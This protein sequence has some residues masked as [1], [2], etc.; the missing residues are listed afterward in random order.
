MM[1]IL[2]SQAPARQTA[3]DTIATLSSRLQSATLLEDRRAAIQGLRSFAKLYPASVA[4]G[5]LRDLVACL[6][7][8]ADDLDTIK[9]VL[10]TILNL[11]EPDANSD[12]ASEE[13]TVWLADEFALKQDNITA[14]LDLLENHDLYPR[15]YSLQIL[16]H[17]AAA[18]PDRTQ[19]AVFAA[20][21]G[22]SRVVAI[23]DDKREMVRN[24]ALMLLIALTPTSAELQKVIAFED[25]FGRVFSIIEAEGGLTHGA[26][27]VQDCLSLLGNLLKLNTSN[28]SYFREIGGVSRIAKLLGTALAEQNTPEGVSEWIKPQRDV[29]VWGLLTLVQLFLPKGAPGTSVNQQLFWQNAVLNHILQLAFHESMSVGIRAKALETCGDIIRSNASLQERFGDLPVRLPSRDVPQING[30]GTPAPGARSQNKTPEPPKPV[31]EDV[32]VI[33]ALLELSLEPAPLSMFD[34]RIASCNCVKA[35]IEGHNGIRIHVLRRAIEGHK[36]G[37]DTI[38]NILTVLLEPSSTRTTSDPYQQWMASVILMHLLVDNPETKELALSV[39][40]GDAENGEEVVTFV[41]S[42]TSNIIAGVQHVEDERALLGCLM[43]LCIWLF[44]TPEAVN[45]LLGEG[46]NVQGLIAA[47]KVSNTSMPL[48]SSLSALLIGIVYEFSTKDSPVPRSSLHTLLT[49]NL[50]RETY[51]DRMTRLREDPL[52]RDFE[53]LP[54]TGNGG[55]PDVFFDKTFVDFLKDNFSRLLRAIDREPG[56]E[57]SI[58]ANGVQKGVSRD[59]VDSLRAE[60]EEQRRVLEATNNDMLQLQRKLEDEELEHRRTRESTTVEL[61]RIKQINQSLQAGHEQELNTAKEEAAREARA[62]KKAHDEE[63]NRRRIENA[64]AMDAAQRQ[65]DQER[66]K[67]GQDAKAAE[68][69]AAQAREKQLK[70][71]K[72]EIEKLAR[73]RE[74][75]VAQH[76]N[77]IE[78][79]ESRLKQ[80]REGNEA[81]LSDLKSQIAQLQNDL[82]KAEKD[83][84]QDLRIAS[85]E[86]KSKNDSLDAK[87]KRAQAREKEAVA[88]AKKLTTKLAE[89]QESRQAV[90]TELDDL[91]VVFGDLEAKRSADKAKLKELGE[92]VSEDE[93]EDEDEDDADG[94]SDVD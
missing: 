50:G 27:T 82:A 85:D 19:D 10:E 30:H 94:G 73:Q 21:L 24:E 4:S 80:V 15:L 35:F 37:D 39:A 17:V 26:T 1:R 55:L 31:L 29:N 22:V 13:I 32:N 7:R 49:T 77:E 84:A 45:D 88:E 68:Q 12:E 2:E 9:I 11:F 81:E 67:S 46:T 76:K 56:F 93:D 6:H 34:V 59:L 14:L 91:L 86:Y 61:N 72:S 62:T 64:A 65:R 47:T 63:L 57:V 36:S 87:L 8:D 66:Q 83:Y 5:G 16:S 58:M 90:Q 75:T 70:E 69:G 79:L 92:E 78:D 33:E 54:Q 3:T 25:A 52:I 89:A 40:E 48:V 23:L 74:A 43:L 44:E 38:P 53:V 60:L 71:H 51:V 42:V 28:Q 41:Q 20:P 18:R